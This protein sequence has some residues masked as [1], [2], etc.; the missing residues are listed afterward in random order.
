MRKIIR[1]GTR[2]SELAITQTNWVIEKLKENYPDLEFEL[3]GITTKGDMILDR[4]LDKIGGKGLF[5]NELEN[6]LLNNSIDMAVHSMKDMPA[7]LP[8]ELVI[9]AIPKR[10]DPRDI[11]VSLEGKALKDLQKGSVIG[12]GSVRREVQILE[13]R[14]DLNTKPI[15]GNVPTR[16]NKLM[17]HQFD[18]IVLAMA[19]LKRL[20]LE[21]K[22]T[23][24]FSHEE[25]VPAV[26]QGALG[27]E[28]R[29]GDELHELLKVI[30]DE[31]SEICINAE[32]AFL[33]RLNGSCSTPLGAYAHI[34]GDYIKI[35]G[36]L[37]ED[38]K[39]DPRKAF[40]EGKKENFE[41]LGLKLA[42]MLQAGGK[43]D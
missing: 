43:Y 16:L 15:R 2:T 18:A 34:C 20:G 19:G 22:V 7:K 14:P 24:I 23:E 32:R 25:M 42:D 8:D 9:G 26:G 5:I 39:T 11:L 35:Y 10:E 27:I 29:K 37:A 6:A 13:L 40:I 31:D 21:D 33:Q 41:E 36:M 28:V 38:D 17:E 30:N 12:T 3:V 1:V 4:S